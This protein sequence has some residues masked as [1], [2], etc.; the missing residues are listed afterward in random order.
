M[1]INNYP[2]FYPDTEVMFNNL[3]LYIC[4]DAYDLKINQIL[5]GEFNIE[6][7][8]PLTDKL[9]PLLQSEI[10]PTLP[11]IYFI[12]CNNIIFDITK[13]EIEK[14]QKNGVELH[15]QG[16]HIRFF[17]N[18]GYVNG[19]KYAADTLQDIIQDLLDKTP[20][21]T[22]RFK[23]ASWMNYIDILNIEFRNQNVYECL[24]QMAEKTGWE[25]DCADMPD[26]DGK[27]AIGLRKPTYSSY[28]YQG[29]GVGTL[30]PEIEIRTGK[31]IR[32]IK[33]EIEYTNQ[34]TRLYGF[35]KSG[36]SFNGA[37]IN[38][39]SD[40]VTP[41]VPPIVIPSNVT[42]I[43]SPSQPFNPKISYVNFSNIEDKTELY[44][45]TQSKFDELSNPRIN[46]D[47]DVV[48]LRFLEQFKGFDTFGVGDV[49]NF[50]DEDITGTGFGAKQ[51][52]RVTE[53]ERY[54]LEPEKNTARFQTTKNNMFYVFND[55]YKT[56]VQ[57]NEIIGED[58]KVIFNKVEDV[59]V[60]N[61][62]N[63]Q[64]LKYDASTGKWKN[65][66]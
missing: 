28:L 12:K 47:I 23:V 29:G 66:F 61:P 30:K 14:T 37:T 32:S 16:E 64:T 5:N 51:P 7:T 39:K 44:W 9:E 33:K 26:V 15:V 42:Y 55:F 60:S 46:L 13:L 17:I 53:Y 50:Y 8:V 24:N 22:A 36:G 49:V 25:I 20:S 59:E 38:L 54:P 35:G 11:R 48:D 62:Q 6:F 34:V 63:N 58:G 43:E 52:I 65:S 57:V 2:I 18:N 3:G 31:N 45:A 4:K 10:D 19:E 27:F 56:T 41:Q 1:D 40:G 21:A